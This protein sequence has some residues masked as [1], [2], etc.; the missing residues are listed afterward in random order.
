MAL[1]RIL[2]DERSVDNV[3]AGRAKPL[4]VC[5]GV[6][7]A[8]VH[9]ST[10]EVS[11]ARVGRTSDRRRESPPG[12]DRAHPSSS[13]LLL[14]YRYAT[15]AR[16]RA[17]ARRGALRKPDRCN[18]TTDERGRRDQLPSSRNLD[19]RDIDPDDIEAPCQQSCRRY[20]IATADIQHPAPAIGAG[21][22]GAFRATV[23]NR[24]VGLQ[25]RRDT[26][27]R[28]CRS[29][30]GR[31]PSPHGARGGDP[32]ADCRQA[33]CPARNRR[34]CLRSPSPAIGARRTAQAAA[35]L[36]SRERDARAH[37]TAD[38]DTAAQPASPPRSGG[39][40]DIRLASTSQSKLALPSGNSS[41]CHTAANPITGVGINGGKS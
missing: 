36:H 39:R 33:R 35:A 32:P 6:R 24:G 29:R 31:G 5:D 13:P 14:L 19:V 2:G 11:N 17:T 15:W 38:T 34:F 21:E 23:D 9:R 18:V 10:V 22:R 27:W 30:D 20:A 7:M 25:H 3:N 37:R 16:P 8:P 28:C 12:T 40:S 41:A 4:A 1:V 26:R